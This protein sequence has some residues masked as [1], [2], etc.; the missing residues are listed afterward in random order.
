MQKSLPPP[1][2]W[3]Y[4]CCPII[5]NSHKWMSAS[6]CSCSKHRYQRASPCSFPRSLQTAEN[7]SVGFI[8]VAHVEIGLWTILLSFRFT[9]TFWR[10]WGKV[11]VMWAPEVFLSVVRADGRAFPRAKLS[12]HYQS[13]VWKW[14]W[15]LS[16]VPISMCISVLGDVFCLSVQYVAVLP[17]ILGIPAQYIHMRDAL[18]ETFLRSHD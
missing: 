18:K 1:H 4:L 9:F 8:T 5:L 13:T 16:D 2:C 12:L 14:S 17:R 11:S 10:W 3:T 6:S 7:S 15:P